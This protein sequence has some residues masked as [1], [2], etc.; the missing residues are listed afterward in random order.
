VPLKDIVLKDAFDEYLARIVCFCF[1]ISPQP[2]V[3]QTNRATAE[4]AKAQATEEGLGPVLNWFKRLIDQIVQRR[5]LQLC[6]EICKQAGNACK[7]PLAA[8]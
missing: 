3:N 2:F 8:F 7:I 1:S 5:F 6:E 4:T